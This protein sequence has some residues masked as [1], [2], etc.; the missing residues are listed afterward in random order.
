MEI[1]GGTWVGLQFDHERVGFFGIDDQYGE[2]LGIFG[3]V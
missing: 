2:G 1:P 3:L